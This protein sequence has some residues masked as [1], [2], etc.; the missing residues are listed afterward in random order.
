MVDYGTIRLKWQLGEEGANPSN[1]SGVIPVQEG[2]NFKDAKTAL[3]D[4][5]RGG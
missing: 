1:G 4:R 3:A 5:G 2:V